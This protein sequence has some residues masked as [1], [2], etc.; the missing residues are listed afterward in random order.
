MKTLAFILLGVAGFA[1]AGE[2]VSV[3]LNDVVLYPA[4][5]GKATHFATLDECVKAAPAAIAPGAKSRCHVINYVTKVGACDV[6]EPPDLPSEQEGFAI[7]CPTDS[8]RWFLRATG[9]E[10]K[11]YPSCQ[12]ELT[13][14]P[15]EADPPICHAPEVGSWAKDDPDS[16]AET[17]PVDPNY[18][19]FDPVGPIDDGKPGAT[20]VD[21]VARVDK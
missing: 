5:G 10:R 13:L 16:I 17:P 2:T 7:Q 20:T 21:K 1:S 19:E 18:D 8:N 12:F 15:K 14:L 11:P 4:D 3:A 9:W 6:A